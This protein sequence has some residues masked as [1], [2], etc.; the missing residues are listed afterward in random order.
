LPGQIFLLAQRF[1]ILVRCLKERVTDLCFKNWIYFRK[2]FPLEEEKPNQGS[3]LRFLGFLSQWKE[4]RLK[5]T[6]IGMD[7]QGKIWQKLNQHK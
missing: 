3:T 2:N 1:K 5:N 7:G 6:L 4:R